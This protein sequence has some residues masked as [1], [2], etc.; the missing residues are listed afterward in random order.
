MQISTS[1]KSGVF[2]VLPDESKVAPARKDEVMRSAEQLQDI[3]CQLFPRPCN[4]GT[5][6]PG[7]YTGLTVVDRLID[8]PET[9]IGDQPIGQAKDAMVRQAEAAIDKACPLAL[10]G[11]YGTPRHLDYPDLNRANLSD[12]SAIMMVQAAMDRV[13]SAH[14]PGA[15][16][17]GVEEDL[18]ALWLDL[19]QH[20]SGSQAEAQSRFQTIYKRY[21]DDKVRLIQEL[22]KAG[23]INAGNTEILLQ[24]E[25]ALYRSIWETKGAPGHGPEY[26]FLA[27]C[28]AVRPAIVNYLLTSTEIFTRHYGNDDASWKSSTEDPETWSLCE[29]LIKETPEYRQ[30]QETGWQGLVPP[31]M[32]A[33]YLAKF[34]QI[35]NN[36]DLAATDPVL[37]FH[38][39][40]YLA[41]TLEKFKAGTLT[42]GIPNGT[43]MIK[44]PLVKP[45]DGRPSQFQALVAQRTFPQL[46][47]PLRK[48]VS[49]TNAS[50]WSSVGVFGDK[51]ARLLHTD[52]FL[53][54]PEELVVPAT[55]YCLEPNRGGGVGPRLV[56]T[57]IILSQK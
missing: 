12:L 11:I 14:E 32:R 20:P 41:S 2:A 18:T 30:L 16:F 4:Y 21:L 52:E 1:E 39:A 45:V 29:R 19:T 55:V 35:L 36:P 54:V 23:L 33:Y 43:P 49:S 9:R 53:N 42:A 50:A 48:K 28:E 40:T 6:Q 25:T 22:A 10:V 24:S 47:G 27:K 56:D 44:V 15:K 13:A 37:N 26:D 34:R 17:Y 51:K 5:C 8:T 3:L 57:A 7:E 31:E 38:V 46:G